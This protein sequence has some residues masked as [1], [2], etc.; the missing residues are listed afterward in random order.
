MWGI[1]ADQLERPAV[2]VW[3]ENRQAV[4]VFL[5]MR[6][7]WRVAGM[8]G[9]VGLDYSALPEVWRRTKTPPADRDEVFSM[10]R[11]MEVAALNADEPEVD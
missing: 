11:I 4:I 6:T 1:T 3:P 9:R 8:G 2:L 7:Q 5:T 10:L